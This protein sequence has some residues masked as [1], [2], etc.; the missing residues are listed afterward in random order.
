MRVHSAPEQVFSAHFDLQGNPQA[1]N[2]Q[3][4]TPL[5]TVLA[6]MQWNGDT[7]TLQANGETQNFDSLPALVRHVTGT[8]LP[9]ASLFAWL[10][11]VDLPASGWQVDLDH[12]V[13][14]RL[15]AQRV[16]PDTPAELKIIL[17]P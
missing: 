4:A 10:H 6:L 11:G 13:S 9:I 3:F 12:I 8:D 15:N 5:G 1:G 2:L 7:A 14:G 16:A 17:D